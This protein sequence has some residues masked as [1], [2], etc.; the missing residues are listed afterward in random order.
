MYFVSPGQW[1]DG[2]KFNMMYVCERGKGER[3]LSDG[4]WRNA[5]MGK[6]RNE[7]RCTV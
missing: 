3:I 1:K 6:S 7:Q 2:K 5:R 4:N